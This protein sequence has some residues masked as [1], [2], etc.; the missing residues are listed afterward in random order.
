MIANKIKISK[1]LV[2]VECVSG[3]YS[4]IDQM[5]YVLPKNKALTH[6]ALSN[7]YFNKPGILKVH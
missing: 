4:L 2:Y 7:Q 1:F 3:R 6:S 5:S